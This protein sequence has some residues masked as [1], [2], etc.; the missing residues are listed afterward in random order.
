MSKLSFEGRQEKVF[1]EEKNVLPRRVEKA[2]ED[3]ITK[4][5]GNTE[6]VNDKVHKNIGLWE[7]LR[8]VRFEFE[9]FSMRHAKVL[10]QLVD[11]VE[12]EKRER[13][14]IE[15]D[16]ISLRTMVDRLP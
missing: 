11:E 16:L 7:E 2:N 10:S 3:G 5:E 6:K 15:Q 13:K 8:K 12:V 1:R 4:H 9:W 14:G